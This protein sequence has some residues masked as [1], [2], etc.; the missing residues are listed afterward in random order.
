MSR[1]GR[2]RAARRLAVLCAAALLLTACGQ[3]AEEETRHRFT[4]MG[5]L[6]DVSIWGAQPL[7][8]EAA[9]R[10]VEALFVT[11]HAA[12]DPWGDGALGTVNR[13]LAAGEAIRPDPDLGVLLDEAAALTE[14]T[15]GLFD[16]AIGAL[17]RLWGFSDD[18]SRPV[19]PPPAGEIAARLAATAPLPELLVD[20]VVQGPPGAQLDLGGFLKGVAVQRGIELLQARG[21]EHAIVNAG[22]DL[23]AIGRRGERAWRIGIRAARDNTIVA[24][25]EVA[26]GEAV[27]TSGDYERYF[28]Y[29]GRHYHHILDPRTGYPT[30]GIASVTVV[31]GDAAL[32]DAGATALLVAGPE[33][34]PRMAETLGL[35]RVLVVF[36]DGAIELT[37]ALEPRIWFTDEEQGRRARVR[38][39]P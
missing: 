12:W 39:L 24:A 34:W 1:A 13:A 26:D 22:G 4:A 33:D 6:V 11:L 27:F 9:A 30:R 16:P 18:E 25:L 17:V 36:E 32:A 7:E 8:A 23:R 38:P 37:G 31:H 14:T 21:I 3:P 19:A 20:G 5:T 15:G 28:D 35:D 2:Q 10:E 29:E